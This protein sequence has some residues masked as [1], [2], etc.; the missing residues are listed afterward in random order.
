VP[1]K[2][3]RRRSIELSDLLGD[4]PGDD[5]DGGLHFRHHP[6]EE[7]TNDAHTARPDF[8]AGEMEGNHQSVEE[9]QP[10]TAL[11]EV[12]HMR[13]H[14]EG[15]VPDTPGLKRT[16][17][18]LELFSGLTRRDALSSQRPVLRKEVRPFESTPAWLAPMVDVWLSWMTG[19]TAT[20]FVHL[21]PVHHHGEGWRGRP[22]V[23]TALGDESAHFS[24]ALWR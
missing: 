15:V 1:G 20:S 22:V 8:D 4:L 10:R 13:T 6:L 14:I 17:G 7:E 12:G 2:R 18:N 19:P 23:S 16:S 24:R 21:A 5:L 9:R 11:Q 3:D